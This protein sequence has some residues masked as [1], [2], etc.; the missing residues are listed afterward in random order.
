MPLGTLLRCSSV[1][2]VFES[3]IG[4]R[5]NE[6]RAICGQSVVLNGVLIRGNSNSRFDKKR[7]RVT[8]P[9]NFGMVF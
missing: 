7:D 1:C 5:E 2:Q 3:E 8:A 9:V 4:N 6:E